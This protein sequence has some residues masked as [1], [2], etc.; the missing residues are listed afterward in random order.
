MKWTLEVKLTRS[1]DNKCKS[2]GSTFHKSLNKGN[3][4]KPL[5]EIEMP[6]T[7]NGLEKFIFPK[8]FFKNYLSLTDYNAKCS[9]LFDLYV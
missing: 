6:I 7:F 4:R 2:R 8:Y 1:E 5:P 9:V 3:Q